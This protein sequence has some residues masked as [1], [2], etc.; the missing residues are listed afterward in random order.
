VV[1]RGGGHWRWGG[2][3]APDRSAAPERESAGGGGGS[4]DCRLL[5]PD[6]NDERH[7][8]RHGELL[9]QPGRQLAS[10]RRSGYGPHPA[11]H[12]DVLLV[13][14]GR[15]NDDGRHVPIWALPA[16]QSLRA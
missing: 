4:P 9:A 10:D 13:V 2:L 3:A 14:P 5:G 6:R 15:D 7:S 11:A 16:T 1:R 8:L 12:P